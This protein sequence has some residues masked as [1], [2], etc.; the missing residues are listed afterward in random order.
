MTTPG[1]SYATNE[2]VERAARW[3]VDTP[4]S[5][6]PPVEFFA[7]VMRSRFKLTTDELIASVRE[8]DR[9]RVLER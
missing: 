9:L 1:I 4:L 2:K 5:Q 3:L 8:T 7:E 6:H